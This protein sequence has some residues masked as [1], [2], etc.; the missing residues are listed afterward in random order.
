M[1]LCEWFTQNVDGWQF[2][3]QHP[4]WAEV[5]GDKLP[6]ARWPHFVIKPDSDIR[7]YPVP[8]GPAA[9]PA[10]LV[11]TAV[12][13]A[14]ASAAYSIY[15]LS[16]M[17]TG[18]SQP[19]TGD[20]LD[21]NPAAA[22][23]AKL[24]DPIREIFGTYKVWPDYIMQPVSRFDSTDPTKYSTSLFL[25]VGVGNLSILAS[26]IRIG[27]TPFHPMVMTSATRFIRREQL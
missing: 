18:G 3:R 27:S 14:V 16:T 7:L 25:C 22:N 19:A 15:M 8:F 26:A 13:I 24:G 20:Q 5:N 1:T 2:E 11:W 9:A 6:V 12:A 21:L 23:M 10:W 17:Q 4:V